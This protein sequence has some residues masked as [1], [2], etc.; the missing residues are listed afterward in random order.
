[1]NNVTWDKH[2]FHSNYNSEKL[3][4]ILAEYVYMTE[5]PPP[6]PGVDPSAPPPQ[7]YQANG[8]GSGIYNL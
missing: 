3:Y 1:M 4:F 6:Y 8:C 5:A 2:Q 7:P